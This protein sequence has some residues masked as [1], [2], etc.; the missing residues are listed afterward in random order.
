MTILTPSTCVKTS[1]PQRVLLRITA[2]AGLAAAWF[3]VGQSSAPPSAEPQ[4]TETQ[5]KASY[6][7]NFARFVTWPVVKDDLATPMTIC[8]FHAAEIAPVLR[9]AV[10]DQ[11]V[12]GKGIAVKVIEQPGETAGCGML[13]IG[14]PADGRFDALMQSVA[15]RCVLTVSDIAGFTERGGMI[16]FVMEGAQVRFKVGLA[17]AQKAN[18]KL[19]SQLLKVAQSVVGIPGTEAR[20]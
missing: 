3:A 20:P 11:T 6:L 17:A 16:E 10:A 2:C 18:L 4:P 19:S 13:F 9:S 5:V 12:E 14:S 1:G 7:Y 15:G 8:V